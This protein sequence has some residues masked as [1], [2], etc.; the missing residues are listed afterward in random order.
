MQKERRLGMWSSYHNSCGG[1]ELHSRVETHISDD[2]DFTKSAVMF[3][4]QIWALVN[5]TQTSGT[6]AK[7]NVYCCETAVMQLNSCKRQ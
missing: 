5:V 7:G 6:L 2:S 1:Q 4:D 3:G